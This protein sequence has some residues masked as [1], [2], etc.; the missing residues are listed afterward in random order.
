MKR[1]LSDI[2]SRQLRRHLPVGRPCQKLEYNFRL[3]H[4]SNAPEQMPSPALIAP[5]FK[6]ALKFE[7]EVVS[8]TEE[9]A[10]LAPRLSRVTFGDRGDRRSVGYV[11]KCVSHQFYRSMSTV[12]Y[13]RAQAICLEKTSGTGFRPPRRSALKPPSAPGISLSATRFP[14]SWRH[15]QDRSRPLRQAH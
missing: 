10:W 2:V 13:T 11:G 7:Q 12:T 1:Q 8:S 9:R 5:R 14:R 6:T 3:A 4:T 15:R